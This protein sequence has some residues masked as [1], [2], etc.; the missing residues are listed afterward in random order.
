MSYIK[1]YGIALP[2]FRVEDST[3]H[4]SG[5]KGVMKAVCFADEDIITLAFE[6][7]CN[8]NKEGVD[9]IF[10]AT[11]SSVFNN[12]YHASFLAD[13]LNLSQGIL[14]LDFT[15]SARSGTDALLLANDLI[16]S[17]KYKNIL[18][19]SADVNFPEI[20][21]ERS[22][23][24][25][26][27]ACAILLCK[28]KGI[29]EITSSGSYSSSLAEEFSYKSNT[30][31]ND[32]RYSRDAGFKNNITTSIKR[33]V[34]KPDSFDA[35][36]LNSLYAR[37]AGGIFAKAGYTET[38]FAKDSLTSKIG[39][40]G[41]THAL[42]LLIHELENGKKSILLAD[43][44]NGTNLFEI[45]TFTFPENKCLQEQLSKYDLINCYQDYLLLRKAGNFGSFT[46][47]T[48]EMFSSEMMQE[49]EKDTLQYL[50]GL[51]CDMCGT[52]YYLKAARC[53][54]CKCETFSTVQLSK[55]GSVYAFTA[56]HYFPSS[57]PPI[58]MVIV[59][60]D[61]GGRMTVQQT[62]T[63]LPEKYKMEIG[64]N[65]KLVLRKMIENDAK[66]NYF[67]KAKQNG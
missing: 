43:Y 12:R 46:Y 11:S 15:N 33:I 34:S 1:S 30:I 23:P 25:G 55:T 38:Q 54:K 29:A 20:G 13:L 40:T 56:E 8:I 9:G 53:K 67:W 36:I 3:L 6:A 19:V 4:P 37:M 63:L 61:G 52:I 28:E 45:K 24:F 14:A 48:K 22:T 59:D 65:V 7:S 32:P 41:S 57:F 51:K 64:V 66:P 62:D 58:T 31:Q 10:F 39:N 44:T 49:R 50:K 2:H 27:A 16:G 60:L 21:K 5:K 18:V 17:G 26:H 42:L 35:I 47:T